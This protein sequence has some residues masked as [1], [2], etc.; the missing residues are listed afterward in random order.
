MS[1]S[2]GELLLLDTHVWIWAAEANTARVGLDTIRVINGAARDGRL[3]VS[4]VSV[5]ELALL[6]TRGRVT[7]TEPLE[8]WI[9]RRSGVGGHRFVSL[10]HDDALA[11]VLSPG[12]LLGDP[13]DRFLIATARRLGARLVTADHKILAYGTAGEVRVLDPGT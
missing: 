3:L 8:T 4:A 2:D 5:W 12:D 11:S 10:T 13:A 1:I 7:L 6:V 9:A